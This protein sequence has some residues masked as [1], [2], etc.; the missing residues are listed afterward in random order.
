VER[1]AAWRWRAGLNLFGAIVTGVVFLIITVAKL[2]RGA[3]IAL[4]AIPLLV[5]VMEWIRA[6]YRH[7]EA[8]LHV[9]EDALIAHLERDQRVVVPVNGI[10]QAVVRA[11]NVGRAVSR[12]IRAVYITD[13]PESGD[14]LRDRWERQ[15]PD[16][17]IVVVESPYRALVGPLRAYLDVLDRT[18]PPDRPAP[19]TVVVLPEY[20][21]RHWWDRMLYNQTTRRLRASIVG[22][23]ATVILEVPY[24]D[25][26]GDVAALPRPDG[27]VDGRDD[28]P[29]A[30]PSG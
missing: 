14:R 15:L 3:W 21:G 5:L 4:V 2:P 16:V 6:R 17:P 27:P 24:R 1:G 7:Q 23:D 19:T 12:D 20:V 30:D 9:D 8:E 25:A 22:R 13:D 26:A 18:W 29:G 28:E 10:N 11:V